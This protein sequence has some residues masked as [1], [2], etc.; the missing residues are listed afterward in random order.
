MPDAPWP[1]ENPFGAASAPRLV[2]LPAA[3]PASPP[4]PA[5]IPA[6]PGAMPAI[7]PKPFEIVVGEPILPV[8]DPHEH[9]YAAIGAVRTA[10]RH[11]GT[12]FLV[13]PAWF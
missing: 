6:G 9:P 12:G 2:E 7:G 4:R 10:R 13:T 11:L 3:A 5:A 1:A 8:P